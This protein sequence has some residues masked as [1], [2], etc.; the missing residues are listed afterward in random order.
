WAFMALANRA[1]SYHS[2][3][4]E[5]DRRLEAEGYVG[6]TTDYVLD[7][8]LTGLHM[9]AG[10]HV[11]LTF[12]DLLDTRIQSEDVLLAEITAVR[13]E[14]ALAVFRRMAPQENRLSFT[15]CTSFIVMHELGVEL[16][17]TADR[18]FHRAGRRI[19]PIFER[20]G[21]LFHFAL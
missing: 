7:E 10:A 3:A 17:F 11:S 20:R 13:R 18:H 5:A 1:D 4:V 9:A 21:R 14:R 6:L 15:D 8:T 2:L 16:A 19:R 12:A